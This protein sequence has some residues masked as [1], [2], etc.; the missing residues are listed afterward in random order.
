VEYFFIEIKN[1]ALCLCKEIISV[2]KD[3]NLKRHYLQKHAT[4][5]DSYQGFFRKQKIL[6]LK[7]CLF[8]QQLN[9]KKANSESLTVTKASYVVSSLIAKKSKPF[10]D[11]KFIKECLESIADIMCPDKKTLFKN[12][13]VSS[14]YKQANR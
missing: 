14:D 1:G 8:S 6:E 5:M 9:I 7:T 11:G 3:Y 13:S 4:K 12:Y 10:I 2:F